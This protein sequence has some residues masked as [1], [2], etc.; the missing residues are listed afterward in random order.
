MKALG[1]YIFGG[2]Q[3]IGHLLEGWEIDTVLEMTDSM[4]LQ[5]SY[6]FIKN[7]PNISVKLPGEYEENEDYIEQLKN[8]KYDLLFSNPPCSGLSQINRN[9]SVDNKANVY[10]YNVID[11]IDTIKPKTFLIENAP[12]LTTTGFPILKYLNK[13]LNDSYFVLILNDLAG[14]H[15]VAMHRRRTLVVGFNKEYFK[16]IPKLAI[17]NEQISV[18]DVLNSIDY[19]YNKEYIKEVNEELFKYYSQVPENCSLYS[20]LADQIDDTSV[21]HES[22]KKPVQKVKDKLSRNE[23]IWDKSPWKSGIDSKF[24]SMTSLTRII[25]PIEN[26]ELYIREYASIMGYPND[27]I[28]YPDECITPTVQCIA[29][30]VPVNFIRYISREIMRSF[31]YDEFYDGEIIYINQTNPKNLKIAAYKTLQDFC[32]ADNIHCMEINLK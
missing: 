12:T 31:D 18:K 32:N 23:N 21:L 20:A 14:N 7:Y 11:M 9:A 3:T 17:E 28:F 6:H 24:P 4:N 29:Q 10:L 30:G 8:T 19:T 13:K 1:M 15:N 27:F 22:L 25:H 16:G 5:N 26:R 2:S